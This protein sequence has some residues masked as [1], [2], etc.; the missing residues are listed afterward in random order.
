MKAIKNY[1]AFMMLAVMMA[2]S[3]EKGGGQGS[4]DEKVEPVFP[5]LVENYDVK[6]GETITL[7]FTPNYNWT[8]SVVAEQ[9]H[10]FL[11][12]DGSFTLSDLHG[13]ASTEPVVANIIVTDQ[14]EFDK[15]LSCDVTLTMNGQTKV[16][17]KYMLPAKERTLDVTSEQMQSDVIALEWSADAAA[18][19]ANVKVESNTEWT[20]ET[21]QWLDVNVPEKT[22]GVVDLV[23]TGESL[24]DA[25]GTV[26]FK[27]GDSVLKEVKVSVPSCMEFEIYTAVMKDGEFEFVDG[28][29]AWNEEQASEIDMMWLGA[30]FRMP[31]NIDAKCNWTVELPE[32]LQMELPDETAGV[33]STTLMGV[34]SKYPLTDT[35]GDIVFKYGET[36]IKKVTVNMP[37]C[38]DIMTFAV[39]MSLTE[40]DYNYLG[41]VNTSTGYITGPAT[42]ILTGVKGVRV[43]AVETT[44]GKVGAE[45][46]EWFTY[47][48]TTWDPSVD[49]PVI[50]GRDI[51]FSVTEN[52][53]D[54]RSA[55]LFVL[56]PSVTTEVTELFNADASVKAEYADYALLV[57]QASMNYDDYIT[58][59]MN[60]SAE[61]AYSFEKADQQKAQQLTSVLGVTDHVYVL[62]YS[63]PY[64]SDDAY[65]TMPIP[66]STFK[67]FSSDDLTADKSE[68]A[69]FWLSFVEAGESNN[70][71]VVNM[72]GNEMPL[73]EESTTGYVVFYNSEGGVLAI[74]E[75]VSPVKEEEPLPEIPSE[76]AFED[77]EGD[78]VENADSYFVDKDAAL[79]SKATMVRVVST[80]DK[81]MKEEMSKGAIV[82]KMTM[83]ADTPVEVALTEAALYYQMPYALN[84]YIKV[85]GE[86]Y[87]ETNGM[88]EKA[89]TKASIS[90]SE[91]DP[92]KNTREFVKFHTSMSETYP[93][94]VVYLYLR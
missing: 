34:P 56:P 18:F 93:F 73:P 12:K 65:M 62:T 84:Q 3:C 58:V 27:A 2:V 60:P 22:T 91:H 7:S 37:G 51:T 57:K 26:V 90:M 74:V 19:I 32:W 43:F 1:I 87:S 33:V 36:V 63:S 61:F 50:Q 53:G 46:P 80:K 92:V 64:C 39:S 48:M 9:R 8:L 16:I 67:V 70:Y 78:T 5:D 54:A 4:G 15:N 81:N 89:I 42:A 69:D 71:G 28:G 38:Q 85:N 94:M 35:K 30:D 20:I 45:N 86:D 79:K 23:F 49:A 25:E 17:A 13:Y 29:Y 82:L 59:H 83:P 11:I 76:G 47:S 6:P 66:Y 52:T 68:V 55:V 10:W 14:Q 44:G 88:L 75:C 41:E 21:P 31:V 72:Y 40:L 77:E 24:E